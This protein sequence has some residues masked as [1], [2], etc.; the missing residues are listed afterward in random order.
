MASTDGQNMSSSRPLPTPRTDLLH[1]AYI[2]HFNHRT[3]IQ[4]HVSFSAAPQ[5]IPHQSPRSPPKSQPTKPLQH[6]IKVTTVNPQTGEDIQSQQPTSFWLPSPQTPRT[7]SSRRS[8]LHSF[9]V[10]PKKEGG[11][12]GRRPSVFQK[13][14]DFVVKYFAEWWLLEILSW[15]F[16]AACMATI[17]IVLNCYDNKPIPQWP[18]YLTLN[19]FISVFSGFARA[20][21]LLPTAEALGQLKWNIFRHRPRSMLDFERLD[22]ASRGPW[23]AFLLLLQTKRL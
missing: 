21:L 3:A 8:G 19:A 14:K 1:P 15:C 6:V 2:P 17:V 10:P 4:N 23:G 18:R 13:I 9:Y 12:F 20:A 5:E 7:L 11:V 22:T 16:S